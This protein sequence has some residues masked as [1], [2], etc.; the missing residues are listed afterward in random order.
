MPELAALATHHERRVSFRLCERRS[1]T[2]L[3]HWTVTYHEQPVTD[4]G[5]TDPSLTVDF[6]GRIADAVSK[7]VF[8]AVESYKRSPQ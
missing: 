2:H 1:A 5:Y 6:F 7:E 3:P 4:T 8:L